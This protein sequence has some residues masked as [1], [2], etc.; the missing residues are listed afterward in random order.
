MPKEKH[1]SKS[2]ESRKGGS[3]K[4][5]R[6]SDK[7][8]TRSGK[9]KTKEEECGQDYLD[10]FCAIYT[11]RDEG[12]Y[13]HWALAVYN[14]EQNEWDILEVVQDETDGPF[15]PE[16]RQINPMSSRRCLQPLTGLGQMHPGWWSA[17][18]EMVGRIPVPG[19]G[20]SWNCQDYVLDIWQG[21]KDA[22]MVD[23]TTWNAGR[24]EVLQY[25]G[26]DF[27]GGAEEDEDEEDEEDENETGVEAREFKS[28]EFIRDSSE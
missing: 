11:P 16:H 3:D 24:S 27:G 23:N 4:G 12:N 9:G 20:L 5:K 28:E 13:Y 15:R 18:V 14:R 2:K 7:D 26:Q 25:Y 19:E 8:K 22:G 6:K 21:M 10:I 17:F 1:K